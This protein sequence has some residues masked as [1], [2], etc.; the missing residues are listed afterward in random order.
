MKTPQGL[1]KNHVGRTFWSLAFQVLSA[2]LFHPMYNTHWWFTII[3]Y[4]LGNN[5]ITQC[6]YSTTGLLMMDLHGP[7]HVEK[8]LW[9]EIYNKSAVITWIKTPN[10]CTFILKSLKF[11]YI[12][13]LYM[14]RTPL[15]PSSGAFQLHMRSL[16]PCGAWFVVSSSPA[17]LQLD[18]WILQGFDGETWGKVATWKTWA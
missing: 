9:N 5:I 11:I 3:P 16:V 7:K 8:I 12:F 2:Y 4:V 14:F 17:V 13:P 10:R 15:C 6:L 1:C 18:R